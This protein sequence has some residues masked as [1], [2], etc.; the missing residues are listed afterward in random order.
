M[1]ARHTVFRLI[2]VLGFTAIAFGGQPP[3]G[4]EISWYTIDG[5]GGI[6]SD[7]A[8]ALAGTIGQPDAGRISN[9]R[10]DLDGGFWPG[11]P[12]S[13]C[14]CLGDL[15]NDGHRNGVDIADFLDCMLNEGPCDC[16]DFNGMNGVDLEDVE[17][18]VLGLLQSSDCP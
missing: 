1:R 16:S 2:M 13:D 8:F 12:I 18:F 17:L 5:G 15:N 9:G 11:V 14:T 3:Q 4:F 10:F 6:S 7:G